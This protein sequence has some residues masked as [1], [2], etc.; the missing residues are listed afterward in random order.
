MRLQV[1]CT[2][3]GVNE[4]SEVMGMVMDF[5]ILF[6][7][8]SVLAMSAWL[9]LL[10][11][12]LIPQWSDRIAG[13]IVPVAL[14][15][16]Y[17][18]LLLFPSSGGGGFGSLASV[19]ELFSHKQAALAGWVHFLAFDLFI[20]AWVCRTAR[21]EGIKFWAVVPCLI[22]TFF[23]GP[24]GFLAFWSVRSVKYLKSEL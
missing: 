8:A 24:A 3:N 2:H 9:T 17:L 11:S 10:A 20:G 19:I 22:L 15:L 6:S 12:P 4:A 14:S 18:G 16:G 23:F 5:E 13:T 7:L 21:Q 1:L